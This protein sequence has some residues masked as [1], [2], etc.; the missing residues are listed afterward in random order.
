MNIV[1]GS[2]FRDS[3]GRQVHRWVEQVSLLHHHLE[4]RG[5]AFRAIAVEGDSVDNTRDQ[6]MRGALAH[7]FD[8]DLRTCNVGG[9]RYFSTEEPERM[10]VLSKVCAAIMDGVA[11]SDDVLVYVE[12]DLIWTPR[13][14]TH[15]IDVVAQDRCDILSPLVFAG[16]NFYDVWAYRK[17]GDRFAPFPPYHARLKPVGLTEVDSVGSCLVMKGGVARTVRAE[18]EHWIEWCLNAR[19]ADYR[20]CV[21]AEARIEHPA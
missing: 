2:A 4:S 18:R 12:S 9:R 6:L 15:L 13:T 19:K 20:I 5:D 1:L 14:I 17:D 8:L 16:H 10:V 21:D 11:S 7:Q 3:A